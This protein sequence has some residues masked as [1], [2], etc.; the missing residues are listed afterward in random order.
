[1]T[2]V[3]EQLP[4]TGSKNEGANT[5]AQAGQIVGPLS[6]D[7]SCT[8]SDKLHALLKRQIRERDGRGRPIA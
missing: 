7:Y 1:M 6:G 8:M 2:T 4:E 5:A 3:P